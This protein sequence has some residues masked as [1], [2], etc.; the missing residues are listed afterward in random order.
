MNKKTVINGVTTVL[1]FLTFFFTITAKLSES[2]KNNKKLNNPL[3]FVQTNKKLLIECLHFQH[4]EKLFNL[5]NKYS[6]PVMI[7]DFDGNPFIW[8]N[9]AAFYKGE[10]KQTTDIIKNNNII[11]ALGV[12]D[13]IYIQNKDSKISKLPIILTLIVF[14]ILFLNYSKKLLILFWIQ[15][16]LIT[17][18]GFGSVI[19]V[20]L[21]ICLTLMYI[22]KNNIN[23]NIAFYIHLLFNLFFIYKLT[24]TNYN[25]FT[26]FYEIFSSTVGIWI[27]LFLI[28]SGFLYF[29]KTEKYY[30]LPLLGACFVSPQLPYLPFTIILL[31]KIF[32]KSNFAGHFLQ[33][34]GFA[35]IT[36]FFLYFVFYLKLNN[37]VASSPLESTKLEENATKALEKYLTLAET[38]KF[39]SLLD[40]VK[41]SGLYSSKYDF[42]AAYFN[43]SG[44][45]N[46][47]YTRGLPEMLSIPQDIVIEEVVIANKTRKVIGGTA[48]FKSGL[49]TLRI[50]ADYNNLPFLKKSSPFSKSLAVVETKQGK[51]LKIILPRLFYLFSDIAFFSVLLLMVFLTIYPRFIKN[52]QGLF[53]KAVIRYFTGFALLTIVVGTMVIVY[54]SNYVNKSNTKKL[55]QTASTLQSIV[56]VY[57]DEI[58]DNYLKWLGTLFDCNLSVYKNAKLI[59][60]G[61]SL[62][63][64]NLL[65]YAYYLKL[66]A[67]N[68]DY[69][70]DKFVKN[71]ILVKLNSHGF[72]CS[73]LQIHLNADSKSLDRLSEVA[74]L[75]FVIISLM[76]FASFIITRLFTAKVVS[77][78]LTLVESTKNI[79]KGNYNINITYKENDELGQ[80]TSSI[81]HMAKAVKD[82]YDNLISLIENLPLAVALIDNNNKV[83]VSNTSFDQIEKEVKEIAFKISKK[84]GER[85]FI[86]GNHYLFSSIGLT[87][88]SRVVIIEDISEVVKVSRLTVLTDMA[89]KISHDI[90]NPLTPIKLN[91]EY[92]VSLS[93]KQPDKLTEAIPKIAKNILN[94]I[95]ELKGISEAFSTLIKNEAID[96]KSSFSLVNFLTS[97]LSSYPE[98]K[99]TINGDDVTVVGIELKLA[100]VIGNLIENSISFA[101]ENAKV[102]IDISDK[103]ELV[104]VIY[105]DNGKGIPEENIKSVFEPYFST[106]ETGTGLGLFIVREFMEE[107]GGSIKAIPCETGAK[108]I[109]TFAK[110]DKKQ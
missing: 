51:Q 60:S 26:I 1:I 77:P 10:Y 101:K 44:T 7:F 39:N 50:S 58:S 61:N 80:L 36:T 59:S 30:F 33:T 82:N 45:I 62:D 106:R 52:F 48:R 8:N 76:L 79:A 34:V 46:S 103:G 102:T 57:S 18:L 67:D 78:I 100:R 24:S 108:F 91:T 83:V 21:P 68:E 16:L 109:L 11:G 81:N 38:E 105:K 110:S 94:K 25:F 93:K 99:F 14:F 56:N 19:L 41:K 107:S 89:R 87:N 37:I 49:L 75:F 104:E 63:N 73:V 88:N 28:S 3:S 4:E 74:R 53:E 47:V 20:Y 98:L 85:H 86:N 5:L 70:F 43:N 54:F 64:S 71:G 65:P 42:E 31:K 9:A 40:F 32:K 84:Q 92:L 6:N 27:I 17:L 97:H 35:I 15:I 90:K 13:T 55:I 72:F 22:E 12:A 23:E 29:S 2:N 69:I 66:C 96:N 95:K